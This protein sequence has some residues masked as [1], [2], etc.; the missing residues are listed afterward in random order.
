MSCPYFYPL[1]PRGAAGQDTML[2]L[3]D[4]W[5]GLCRADPDQPCR[6]D[7]SQV[8]PLCN[9]GYARELCA[10]FPVR[11]G[12]D[13][14][15]FCVSEDDEARVRLYYVLECD[16]LPFAHGPLEY[17]CSEGAFAVAPADENL[18]RQARVYVES[19]LRRKSEA[20]RP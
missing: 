6:P 16:H 13:A 19:Y 15:R 10:R 18:A 2:P 12:P 3:G 1:E 20:S 9:F 7:E 14:V 11:E 8:R 4:A 5:T 17:S